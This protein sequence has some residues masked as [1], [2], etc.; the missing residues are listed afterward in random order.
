MLKTTKNV[1]IVIPTY[2]EVENIE[3]II[4]STQSLGSRMRFYQLSLLI[5]DD[6]SPDGTAAVVSTLLKKHDNITLLS[7][8]K[9]GLGQAYIRGFKYAIKN[10]YFDILI[11]MDADFSHNPKDIPM[12]CK[13]LDTR[14]DYVIGSRYISGGSTDHSWPLR[15][16]LMSRIANVIARRL[17]NPVITINDMTSGFKAI[18]RDALEQIDLDTINAKGYVFQISLLHA[19]LVKKFTVKEVPIKFIDRAYGQS[20]VKV[21][22]VLEFLYVT[23]KLNPNAPIQRFIRFGIVGFCGTIVNLSVLIILIS[24]LKVSALLSNVIGIEVSIISNFFLNHYYT[25]KGYGVYSP[26]DTGY[27]RDTV[28]R[29]LRFNVGTLGGA[30]IN[31]IAFSVLFKLFHIEYIIAD[32][33]AILVALGWNY[34]VST[35]FVWKK[36]DNV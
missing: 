36:V 6:N 34:Y 10:M 5:I 29:L 18:K 24:Q 35:R 4:D 31:F 2:N 27:N 9:A 12:L 25:F 15:R 21:H 8:T 17:V 20:K 23:Y 32:I 33:V 30:A 11:M 7:G 28:R 13:A 1:L 16:I 14:T 19:F 26:N 22:D 3:A